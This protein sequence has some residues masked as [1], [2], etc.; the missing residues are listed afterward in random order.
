LNKVSQHKIKDLKKTN[1]LFKLIEMNFYIIHLERDKKRKSNVSKIKKSLPGKVDVINAVDGL[2]LSEDQLKHYK[3]KKYLLPP[4]PF[5]L[6][7][8]EI[9]CFLSHRKAWEEIIKSEKKGAIILEDDIE[10][11][12]TFLTNTLEIITKHATE[13]DFI[14]LPYKQREKSKQTHF[15][16]NGVSL[17]SPKITGLGMQCQFVGVNA[18]KKI[19][20][21]TNFFDRPVDTTIQ[22]FWITGIRPKVIFPSGV[23]EISNLVGGTSI[24][25]YEQ[26]Y[27][28]IFRE[29]ARPLYRFVF[30]IISTYKSLID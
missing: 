3:K 23:S 2:E 5:N 10:I 20:K 27:R 16:L 11:D 21:N 30:Y 12:E 8:T 22:M 13:N 1:F 29:I 7:N 28:K 9:A 18:A 15:Q 17:F 19:L 25:S 4:Y 14:R 26:L 6:R 24:H